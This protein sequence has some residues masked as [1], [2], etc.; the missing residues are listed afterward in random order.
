MYGYQLKIKQY[1]ESMVCHIS[2]MSLFADKSD[3]HKLN[4]AIKENQKELEKFVFRNPQAADKPYPSTIQSPRWKS[5]FSGI[6]LPLEYYQA[7]ATKMS[8]PPPAKGNKLLN[9]QAESNCY[10]FCKDLK[11]NS[12][13]CSPMLINFNVISSNDKAKLIC[14]EN[15]DQGVARMS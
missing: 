12:Y 6:C 2:V 9:Q 4:T 7:S 3:N 13:T 14:S 15:A 1:S 10:T 8:S 11:E 5:Q